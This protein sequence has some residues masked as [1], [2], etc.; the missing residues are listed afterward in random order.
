MTMRGGDDVSQPLSLT[1]RIISQDLEVRAHRSETVEGLCVGWVV[2]AAFDVDVEE[3]L[4]GVAFHGT[5]LEVRH[6]HAA[7]EEIAKD[8]VE[9]ARLM[10]DGD[11]EGDL[12]S[13]FGDLH[14]RGDDE[15]AGVVALIE[16]NIFREDGEAVEAVRLATAAWFF[17]PSSA[18]RSALR[19]VEKYGSSVQSLC[20]LKKGRH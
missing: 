10:L 12:V 19:D 4:E 7:V 9:R 15:E 6:I 17:L 16:I 18:T 1:R 8:V 14:L 3:V 5:G 13:V 20:S 11:D 2:D